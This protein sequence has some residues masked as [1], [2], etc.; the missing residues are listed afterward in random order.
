MPLPT[1]PAAL[2][3]AARDGNRAALSKLL[4]IA[5]SNTPEAVAAVVAP[6]AGSA[7]V[8]GLTGAPGAGK[9]TLVDASIAHLRG[10]GSA[11]AVLAIDPSSPFSGGAI[12]GD[13]VRMQDHATDPGV[14]IRSMA[15]RGALGGVAAATPN[16]IRV[17]EAAGMPWVL[18]ETV[19]V[20]QVEIEVVETADTVV[21]V[22]NPGWGDAVQAAKAGL[23]EIAD[24]FCVNKAD[25][26]GADDAVR[27]LEQML[28]LAPPG[29]WRPPVVRTVAATG[30]GVAEL[31]A[32]VDP[33]RAH[34]VQSGELAQRRRAHVRDEVRAIV[35]AALEA[36]VRTH[37]AGEA[38]EKLVDEVVEGRRDPY[39]AARVLAPEITGSGRRA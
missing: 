8:V 10:H 16:A 20:G 25:R 11:V 2:V 39:D 1:D 12:L 17:F 36:K 27:D 15:S 26:P 14:F 6:Y 3:T 5:E 22:V 31:W 38:F 37:L 30:T 4:S 29:P 28:D 19:G 23:L 21:V 33:H 24:V 35:A 13:R 7:H 32:A 18:L 9:S 34:L